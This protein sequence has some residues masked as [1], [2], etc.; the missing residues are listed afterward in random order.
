[1]KYAPD[2]IK[3]QADEA[4]KGFLKDK[5]LKKYLEK[6]CKYYNADPIHFDG[7]KLSTITLVIDNTTYGVPTDIDAEG[8][9]TLFGI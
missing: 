3:E 5:T 9:K 1:M 6:H 2:V 7:E 4:F 8:L